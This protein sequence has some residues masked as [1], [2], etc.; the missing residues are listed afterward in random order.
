[1]VTA[2]LSGQQCLEMFFETEFL[3]A[4]TTLVQ[5]T[6]EQLTPLAVALIVQEQP[7]LA[8]HLAAVGLVRIPAAHDA[9]SASRRNPRSR[10]T[11]VSMSRNCLRPRCSRDITVPIGVP[12][13]SA[14]SLYA[15]PS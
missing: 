1:M 6:P 13:I 9:T 12:M 7:Q 14:I 4:R 11:P 2:A 3:Q 8:E 10:A 15:N 5:M